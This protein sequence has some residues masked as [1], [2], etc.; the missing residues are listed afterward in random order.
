VTEFRDY[1]TDAGCL[2]FGACGRG[3]VLVCGCVRGVGGC[4]I[5]VGRHGWRRVV[6]NNNEIFFSSLVGLIEIMGWVKKKE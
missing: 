4:F 5:G 6:F 2:L 3:G 1:D